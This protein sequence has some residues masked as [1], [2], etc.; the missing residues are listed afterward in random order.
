MHYHISGQIGVV[1]AQPI[2]QPGSHAGEALPDHSRVEFQHRR[3]VIIGLRIA[4]VDERH[5]VDVLRDVGKDLGGP[6]ARLAVLFPLKR[7]FETLAAG[8]KESRFGVRTG[9]LCA[10][11]FVQFGLVVKRVDL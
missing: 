11:T 4:G 6:R 8:G 7:R 5:V 3:C 2:S 1:A 10:V 9:K